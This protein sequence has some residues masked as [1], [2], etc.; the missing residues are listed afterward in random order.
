MSA[1][2]LV[3]PE[4]WDVLIVAGEYTPGLAKVTASRVHKWDEKKGKGGAGSTLTY[5]GHDLAEGTIE[6]RMWEEEQ[7]N[8]FEAKAPAWLPDPK[9]PKALDVYHPQL[10]LLKIKSIVI[11]KL[12]GVV[13]SSDGLM[14]VT[15]DFLEYAP[16]KPA[17][18]TPKGSVAHRKP[19]DDPPNATSELEKRF[20]E[21]FDEAKKP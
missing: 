3:T 11:K 14:T 8:E 16:P 15:I 7:Y 1:N 13:V 18:G 5:A 17:G 19:G 2:P 9:T 21:L 12:G 4:A 6:I 10:E 20:G